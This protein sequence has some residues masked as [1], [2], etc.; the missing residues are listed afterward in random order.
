MITAG[1]RCVLA[2]RVA[3]PGVED[4]TTVAALIVEHR[5][6]VAA[7]D[8]QP[9]TWCWQPAGRPE[10]VGR[11]APARG[12]RG[13]GLWVQQTHKGEIHRLPPPPSFLAAFLHPPGPRPPLARVNRPAPLSPHEPPVF[14]PLE[15]MQGYSP[16]PC[17]C[18]VQSPH[19]GN[20]SGKR[21]CLC[22]LPALRLVG[23]LEKGGQR[24]SRQRRVYSP[25][26]RG[27]GLLSSERPP[28]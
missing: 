15:A 13:T 3:R 22:D 10:P 26:P 8:A 21:G 1:V 27:P 2:R 25:G 14:I 16:H 20:T 18:R 19:S 17:S 5:G 24:F 23:G 6:P 12:S 4:T 7:V 11:K 9:V 28:P